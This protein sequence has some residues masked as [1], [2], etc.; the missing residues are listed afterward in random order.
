MS[1]ISIGG[2]ENNLLDE[3][4]LYTGDTFGMVSGQFTAAH[5]Y[6]SGAYTAARALID[7]LGDVEHITLEPILVE[8]VDLDVQD[9]DLSSFVGDPGIIYFPP[10][11]PVFVDLDPVEID[12]SAVFPD[13]NI[14]DP[15]LD[16]TG[17]PVPLQEEDLGV[18]P[19][20]SDADLPPSPGLNL[21]SAP[22]LQD[23]VIPDPPN[24]TIP[25]FDAVL[26][27]EDVDEPAPMDYTHATYTSQLFLDLMQK[28]IDNIRDGGTGLHEDVEEAVYQRHLSRVERENEKLFNQVTNFF[29]ARGHTLPPG[30]Y[31]GLLR[32]VASDIIKNN[33]DASNEIMINQAEL[34]QKNTHFILDLALKL[35]GQTKEFFINN[36][37]LQ[38]EAAK[39]VAEMA[40][41]IFRAKVAK[42]QLYIEEYKAR[43][44]VYQ[45]RIQAALAQVE[46][47]RA[48][49]EAAKL[50]VEI[51]ALLVE[52]YRA[53]IS[54]ALALVEIYKAD[55]EGAKIKA[56]IEGLRLEGYKTRI[57]AYATKVSAKTAEWN[58][59]QAKVAGQAIKAQ[60]YGEQVKAFSVRVDATSKTVDAQI[61]EKQLQLE[62]AKNKILINGHLIEKYKAQIQGESAK[63]GSETEIYKADVAAYSA[64]SSALVSKYSAQAS[65]LNARAAVARVKVDAAIA[66]MDNRVKAFTALQ[67][68]RTEAIKGG[69]Q[70][71]AQLAAGA[72]S[73]IHATASAAHSNSM[74]YGYNVSHSNMTQR[75]I[76]QIAYSASTYNVNV[77]R[78]E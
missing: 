41:E 37:R 23:V 70:V 46:I 44:A 75:I 56:E 9:I 43:A 47:F 66:E 35:E 11:E 13:F 34:A 39:V 33:T 50:S 65:M 26:L 25:E 73:S 76:Q 67:G 57:Q 59:Y 62:A 10:T 61:S 77:N 19:S 24:I 53:Q 42:L 5:A 21:P 29:A 45:T 58:G 38:F 74:S 68:L 40:V 28:T 54:A 52:I 72:L 78:N 2:P 48:R 64:E 55:M 32:E 16:L 20:I 60:V 12:I 1:W 31:V 30:A 69:A 49:V 63:I 14:P 27:L 7:Q 6:A 3:L 71:A 8:D 4:T 17:E 18:A 22:T 15:E 36:Q 51:Q